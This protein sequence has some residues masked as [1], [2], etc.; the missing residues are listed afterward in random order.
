MSLLGGCIWA[1]RAHNKLTFPIHFLCSLMS[2][3][4]EA[5]YKA[6][7]HAVMH[8]LA[9][10][11]PLRFGGFGHSTLAAAENPIRPFTAGARELGLHA[12]V[13]ANITWA[14]RG[15]RMI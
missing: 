15:H 10:P 11:V 8:E 14:R 5:V 7:K 2:N 1:A 4:S 13:D 6:A 12:F 3:P 9:H